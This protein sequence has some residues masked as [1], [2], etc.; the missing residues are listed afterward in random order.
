MFELV[1]PA[2]VDVA[3]LTACPNVRLVGAVPHADVVRYMRR[4]DVGL[5]PYVV[6][7]YTSALRPVKL[8]EYLA[9]G[10]P[11][12][13]THLPEVR[14]FVGDHGPVVTIADGAEAFAGAIRHALNED[15]GT[16][17]TQRLDVARRYDWAI[18]LQTMSAA[19]ETALDA[20]SCRTTRLAAGAA[21]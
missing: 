7:P 15:G 10:L 20:G 14:R 18:Q 21:L 8:V 2:V 12:V 3:L 13:S 19:M 1:G 6:N 5:L 4:F 17:V 9:A 11:V 16:A